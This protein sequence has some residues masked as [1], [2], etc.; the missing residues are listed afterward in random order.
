M[1]VPGSITKHRADLMFSG[2]VSMNSNR[3]VPS[4]ETESSSPFPVEGTALMNRTALSSSIKPAEANA[5]QAANE[6]PEAKNDSARKPFLRK[7][8]PHIQA[9]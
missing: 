2:F 4:R 8:E 5:K 1:L 7:L 9:A 3:N 6:R